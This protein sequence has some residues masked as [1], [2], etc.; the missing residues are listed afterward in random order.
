[1]PHPP[2]RIENALNEAKVNINEFKSA[3]EQI[4]D[5]IKKLTEILPIKYEIKVLNIKI[6]AEF[7]GQSYSI[8]K[9]FS[10]ILKEN[11]LNDGS[12]LVTV[13]VPAGLQNELFDNLN[14]L[15][16]GKIEVTETKK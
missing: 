6:P 15:A 1:M 16:H 9:R 12:L 14:N 13:E 11:W 7:S 3:D 4:Q 10:N 2:Q 8:L 5:I